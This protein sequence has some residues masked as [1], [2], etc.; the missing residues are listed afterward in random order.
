M[1]KRK[2]K[3]VPE[4]ILGRQE[5]SKN[6]ERIERDGYDIREKKQGKENKLEDSAKDQSFDPLILISS[7][8]FNGFLSCVSLLLPAQRQKRMRK[9]IG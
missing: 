1:A 9:I 4:A 6:R 5:V 7:I 3:R 2:L 8:S